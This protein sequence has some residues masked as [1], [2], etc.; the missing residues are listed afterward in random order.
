MFGSA[1]VETQDDSSRIYSFKL[2]I[3]A[4]GPIIVLVICA[5]FWLLLSLVK[6]DLSDFKIKTVSATLVIFFVIHPSIA[7]IYF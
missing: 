7:R 6:R 5:V 2:I 1:S 3:F 4:L